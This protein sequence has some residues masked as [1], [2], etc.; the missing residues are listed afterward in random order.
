MVIEVS[1]LVLFGLV[2]ARMAGLASR[3]RALGEE[4]HRRR[5][6]ERFA[7][8]VRHSHDLVLVIATDGAVTYASPSVE[9]VLGPD[10]GADVFAGATARGSSAP[11][12]RSLAG[13]EIDAFEYTVTDAARAQARVFEVRLTNLIGEEHVDG[14]L[15][16][17][18][19]VSERKDVR[20][21]AHATRRST[22]G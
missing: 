21:R 15:L 2:V 6:E 22:T 7:A 16:N 20:G 3:Q 4:L 19:D 13:K 10:P 1:S 5:G 18:H 8:L 12:P 9:Q 14:I 17:A 11:S